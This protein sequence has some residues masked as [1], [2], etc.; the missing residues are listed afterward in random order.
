[1]SRR[2]VLLVGPDEYCPRELAAVLD[3]DT[4]HGL[5]TEVVTLIQEALERTSA[6]GFDAV[7]CWAERE[8]E[9]AGIIRI[10]KAS[11]ELPIVV[12]TSQA[13]PGF[14]EL[15]R[16]MGATGV[17]GKGAGLASV[18][19]T[20]RL[21]LSTG[22]LAREV[23]SQASKARSQAATIRDL[24]G[25]NKRL[26]E[27]ALARVGTGPR[28][29]LLPLLVEDEA[30]QAL[31]LVR[32]FHK[33]DVFAPLPLMKSG[34]EAIRYLSGA[35]PFQNR[36]RFPLPTL[37][38]LDVNLPGISGLDVLDWIKGEPSLRTLRV[39]ML[40]SSSDP[41]TVN[42][43]YAAGADAFLTKPTSFGALVALVEGL[44]EH[45]GRA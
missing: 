24:A 5:A 38:L 6:R 32:A 41:V 12:L 42:R 44:Q 45:S 33:A 11:P 37:V 43:A 14:E 30:D 31:L 10:R 20:L 4:E 25:V 36:S 3:R 7:V 39:V 21:A 27:E 9:L 23:R 18:S 13:T 19:Q 35:A 26:S 1:M 15:A 16:R 2:K 17:I 8:D 28:I 29:P 34:E 40:S 22:E